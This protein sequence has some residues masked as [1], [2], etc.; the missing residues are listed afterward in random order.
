MRLRLGRE[1]CNAQLL[2][3]IGEVGCDDR[4]RPKIGGGER[5]KERG[6]RKEVGG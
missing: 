1:L 4:S 5:R 2:G 6:R 3:Q